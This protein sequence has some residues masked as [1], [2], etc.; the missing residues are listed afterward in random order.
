MEILGYLHAYTVH[1]EGVGIEYNLPN[2]QL[3]WPRIPSSAWLSFLAAGMLIAGQGFQSFAIANVSTRVQTP[4][5]GCLNARYGPGT[6]HS[7]HTCVRNGAALLPVV[8]SQG[9][10]LQLSSGRWVYGPFT[11][12]SSRPQPP[13]INPPT[14]ISYVTPSAVYYVP[15]SAVPLDYSYSLRRGSQG[16]AV[17][18]MQETLESLNYFT[19]GTDGVYGAATEFAVRQF[20]ADQG[21]VIDGVF[22]LNTASRLRRVKRWS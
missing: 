8:A 19:G 18:Q 14:A 7:V 9:E 17:R 1:E 10:W 13:V 12:H 11:T 16:E 2:L 22:N 6:N 21:L 4:N 5:G 15:P 20:Q 3:G